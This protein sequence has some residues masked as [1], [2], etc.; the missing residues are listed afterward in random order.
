MAFCHLLAALQGDLHKTDPVRTE[1]HFL[2]LSVSHTICVCQHI[3]SCIGES[4]VFCVFLALNFIYFGVRSFNNNPVS[5]SVSWVSKRFIPILKKKS[6]RGN[7]NNR[8]RGTRWLQVPTWAESIETHRCVLWNHSDTLLACWDPATTNE[9][10]VLPFFSSKLFMA[11]IT[12][13]QK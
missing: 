8:Q 3:Y 13:L 1:F 6:R 2:L 10:A 12:Y 5:I 9:G 4:V 11:S 7:P